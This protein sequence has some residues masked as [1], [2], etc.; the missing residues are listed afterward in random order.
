M[1][2]LIFRYYYFN[3]RNYWYLHFTPLTREAG[4]Q[5]GKILPKIEMAKTGYFF[6]LQILEFKFL[7]F[8]LYSNNTLLERIRVLDDKFSSIKKSIYT[9]FLFKFLGLKF[10]RNYFR[11]FSNYLFILIFEF[12]PN[13]S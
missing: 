11:T 2:I 5:L 9:I 10:H 1:A 3:Y 8:K 6:L 7:K 4:V 12:L 13:R